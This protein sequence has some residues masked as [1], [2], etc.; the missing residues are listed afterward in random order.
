M[1][2][3]LEKTLPIDD[4]RSREII[5]SD[6]EENYFV[7]ASAGSGKTTSLVY[8]MVALIEKGVPVEKICTITFTKAAAD[9]F[10]NR[11]QALLS[12][13]SILAKDDS[14]DVLG[15]KS[16]ESIKLCQIALSNI[17]SCFLG[18]IDAFCT[19]I[20][21]QYCSKLHQVLCYNLFRQK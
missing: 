20:L 16:E 1:D 10:F 18:T 21:N 14:D 17:D 3:L 6:L 13:R 5:V 12:T 9:E 2:D 19:N 15:E 8:R 7:E 11:F 4:K